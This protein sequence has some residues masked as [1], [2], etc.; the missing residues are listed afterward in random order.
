MT[1]KYFN[2]ST[3]NHLWDKEEIKKS[4]F[5]VGTIITD[6]FEVVDKSRPIPQCPYSQVTVRCGDSPSKRDVRESDG[7]FQISALVDEEKQELVL[8]LKSV[9]YQGLGKSEGEPMPWHIKKLH[10]AYA[11]AL[12]ENG[13][14]ELTTSRLL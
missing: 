12:L 5:P 2:E 10:Q 11:L 4:S 1:K 13:S 14:R 9:F 7:L 8:G 3:K 6:H